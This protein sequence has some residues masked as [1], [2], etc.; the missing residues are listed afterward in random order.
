MLPA[1]N[2]VFWTKPIPAWRVLTT[3]TS[4]HNW[5][6]DNKNACL[7]HFSSPWGNYAVQ[8]NSRDLTQVVFPQWTLIQLGNRLADR[9][10][11][12]I[13]FQEVITLAMIPK[14]KKEKLKKG[15]H[16][17]AWRKWMTRWIGYQRTAHT[18]ILRYACGVYG[19]IA[20]LSLEARNK[21]L[22]SSLGV[23]HVIPYSQNRKNPRSGE[24]SI[25]LACTANCPWCFFVH[26]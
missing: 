20:N 3:V 21:V 11:A 14:R 25:V 10:T 26:E 18:P 6:L 12:I 15:N 1:E 2:C 13:R 17:I 16:G 5:P 4:W 19:M 9:L 23:P 24:W 7:L 22:C 8:R